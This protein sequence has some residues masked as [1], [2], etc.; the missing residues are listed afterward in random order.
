ML[1]LRL[2]HC[3]R[4]I[5]TKPTRVIAVGW[6]CCV[7]ALL[8]GCRGD[9]HRDAYQSVMARDYRVLE[10]QLNE[11]DY[12]NSV[13]RDKLKRAEQR[14]RACDQPGNV[15]GESL[16]P[17]N[18]IPGEAFS[19]DIMEHGFGET[20]IENEA[21]TPS[22]AVPGSSEPPEPTELPAPKPA[23]EPTPV[24]TPDGEPNN[25]NELPPPI[26]PEPPGENDTNIPKI[27]PGDILP[28][29]A[30]GEDIDAPP[31][32][33]DLPDSLGTLSKTPVRV[34]A[35]LQLHPGLSGGHQF[36]DDLQSEGMYLVVNVVDD[37]GR[38]IDLAGF[39]IEA[40]MSIVALDPTL[41]AANARIARWEFAPEQLKRFVR[42]SPVSGLH[43]PVQWQE[44]LPS[45]DDV[46]VHVRLQ[47]QD[48]E[49][50]CNAR[51]RVA[52]SA[53]IADWT[54]RGESAKR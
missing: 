21:F 52:K 39:D 33:I 6:F 20:V 23:R 4:T 30:D 42:S 49:M 11:A 29:P 5:P 32:K 14:A 18:E 2:H 3:F 16:P 53:S 44:S 54:P 50:R 28:P 12:Q 31:G 37:R 35:G 47:T 13:L 26:V 43:I 1:R 48:E 7:F 27:D 15:P 51:L 8:L 40:S 38:M 46:I 17:M 34:P 10:D 9:A 45:G 22:P 24:P 36:D 25:D 19:G 41:E